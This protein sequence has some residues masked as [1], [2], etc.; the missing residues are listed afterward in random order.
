MMQ[1]TPLQPARKVPA[2]RYLIDPAH[3]TV[4]FTARKLGL[5]S[6]HGR[7]SDVSG[8]I[9]IAA[10]PQQSQVNVRV[11]AASLQTRIG[12]RDAHLTSPAFLDAAAYPTLRFRS[13]SLQPAGDHWRLTGD[14]TLH[15][16]TR[17]VTLD[18]QPLGRSPDDGR[19]RLTATA[20]LR[21]S[22]FGVS[23]WRLVVGEVVTVVIQAEATP[24]LPHHDATK[25]L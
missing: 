11:A 16:V 9:D 19:L 5:F 8:C 4:A 21:R 10:D 20:L 15:G 1:T 25:A 13:T 6:V 17:P 3:T 2:G 24:S 23:R 14:L 12:Q 7:F 18:V 22:E